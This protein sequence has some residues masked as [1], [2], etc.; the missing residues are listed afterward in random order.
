MKPDLILAKYFFAT[1]GM[2]VT[3]IW[4]GLTISD[5]MALQIN[6]QLLTLRHLGAELPPMP[7]RSI[8]INLRL[9]HEY[10]V[11]SRITA[12]DTDFDSRRYAIYREYLILCSSDKENLSHYVEYG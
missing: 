7:S 2:P 1:I 11:C 4:S 12:I 9:L 8:E 10:D 6:L 3:P 5:A